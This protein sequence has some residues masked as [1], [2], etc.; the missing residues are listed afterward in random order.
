MKSNTD[1][2]SLILV[3]LMVSS[4]FA[5]K[6]DAPANK[7]YGEW[8]IRV[9]PDQGNVY[10]EL[11]KEK[12]LPL[13]RESGGR[14]VG[15]WNT[16]IGNVYEHVTIWEHGSM[17][18]FEKAVK[19]LGRSDKF[20][21]FVKLRDPL[22]DGED[23]RFLRLADGG[24]VPALPETAA[25]VIHELHHVPFTKMGDY[26]RFMRYSGLATLKKHGFRPVGPLVVEVGKWSEVT[27]LFL[28]KS[29]EEREQLRFAF[30]THQD[31]QLY[32]GRLGALVSDLTTRVLVPSPLMLPMGQ[33]RAGGLKPDQFPTEAARVF[34]SDRSG[35]W[36]FNIDKMDLWTSLVHVPVRP[37]EDRA[38]SILLKN[39]KSWKQPHRLVLRLFRFNR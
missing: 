15:W 27:Y 26:L 7:V 36:V 29:L 39:S 38:F 23:S 4:S 11:I 21:E 10:N 30:Q 25:L 12:G 19:W 24:E 5:G 34:D 35:N 8:L 3:I 28:F 18:D 22:L 17:A 6:Q 33:A 37:D 32:G 16:L 13:F 14:M 1:G 31:S 9:K 20:A 2:L